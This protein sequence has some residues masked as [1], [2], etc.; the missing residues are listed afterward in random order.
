[1]RFW[2]ALLDRYI[3]GARRELGD[4]A[5]ARIEAE[6]RALSLDEAMAEALATAA[7]R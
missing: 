7:T 1:M 6:G 4:D 5:A 2:D 3:G